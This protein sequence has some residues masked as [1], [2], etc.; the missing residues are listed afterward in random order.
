MDDNSWLFFAVAGPIFLGIFIWL[1]F[2][3]RCARQQQILREL[4]RR[5]QDITRLSP[6]HVYP[7]LF[8]AA[9]FIES[10]DNA[11]KVEP[12]T[13]QP[14]ATRVPIIRF[15]SGNTGGEDSSNFGAPAPLFS[16]PSFTSVLMEI[17]EEDEEN[18]VSNGSGSG[19]GDGRG[20]SSASSGVG[21]KGFGGVAVGGG[22]GVHT[23]FGDSG[24][25]S[26]GGGFR[27][28]GGARSGG[29]SSG[30]SAT[31]MFDEK[32]G[33]FYPPVYKSSEIKYQ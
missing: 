16:V 24:Y 23:N 19:N 17:P 28:S 18:I 22:D 32:T 2:I 6:L 7:H 29:N 15:Q 4:S 14:P 1:Y 26:C 25:G 31:K 30:N 9:D 20:C 3:N 5:E 11:V 21:F 10:D 13:D 27:G 33:F 8:K 12:Q